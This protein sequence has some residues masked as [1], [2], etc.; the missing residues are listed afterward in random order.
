MFACFDFMR[1]II[2]SI[3]MILEGVS[4]CVRAKRCLVC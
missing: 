4:V 2:S 3:G 1:R